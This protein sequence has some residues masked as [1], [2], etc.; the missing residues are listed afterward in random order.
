MN[1]TKDAIHGSDCRQTYSP[2]SN[3]FPELLSL[4][5]EICL[6]NDETALNPPLKHI[7]MI[8]PRVSSRW[9]AVSHSTSKL[10]S[11]ITLDL[12]L[13]PLRIEPHSSA[14]FRR[15]E[16]LKTW[17]ARSAEQ[18]LTI[19]LRRPDAYSTDYKLCDWLPAARHL[20]STLL[21]HA[22]RWKSLTVH[23]PL[24]SLVP[25]FERFDGALPLLETIDIH[26]PGHWVGRHVPE[27]ISQARFPNAPR[28]RN[29]S[30]VCPHTTLHMGDAAWSR[31]TTLKLIPP[32]EP[33][34]SPISTSDAAHILAR[35]T[36]LESCFLGIG[37]Q[38]AVE[39]NEAAIEVMP[40]W[41]ELELMMGA[42]QCRVLLRMLELP[43]LTK[44][45]V[46]KDWDQNALVSFL[47]RL[48]RLESFAMR[49]TFR[50][51]DTQQLE[52]IGRL[53]KVRSLSLAGPVGWKTLRALT[54]L[55][56]VDSD[57]W[58]LSCPHLTSL[59]L[60]AHDDA[61]DKALGD[62]IEARWRGGF[63]GVSKMESVHIDFNA[64]AIRSWR[65][66]LARL[67]EFREEGL[68]VSYAIFRD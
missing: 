14:M 60:R 43:K 33:R 9:R 16:L 37:A 36:S 12:P 52:I 63:E 17:I 41:T 18:P 10:W 35:C 64:S 15:S 32:S 45:A 57:E 50:I 30:L 66:V 62:M 54:P 13:G 27:T 55:V 25:L 3:L 28:L 42:S 21:P 8:M 26:D 1:S 67:D 11:D 68:K 56:G 48:T 53:P 61:H 4:I 24:P 47:G 39:I 6:S 29:V 65:G 23:L 49:D 7:R 22:E 40:K 31:L 38:E 19:V 2:I 59:Q 46:L 51:T 44:L 58:E 20:I 5:F 34:S